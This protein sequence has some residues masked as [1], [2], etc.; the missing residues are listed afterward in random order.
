MSQTIERTP[1]ISRKEWLSAWHRFLNL[2]QADGLN[3]LWCGV[4]GVDLYDVMF[5]IDV[6]ECKEEI[7]ALKNGTATPKQKKKLQSILQVREGSKM[8]IDEIA[9]LAKEFDRL[10]EV[11]DEDD[12]R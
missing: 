2:W 11:D 10:L 9:S 5:G 7:E 4:G 1:E 8:D 6:D 12:S 3:G